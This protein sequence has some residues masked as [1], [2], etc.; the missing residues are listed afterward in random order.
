MRRS[1]RPVGELIGKAAAEKVVLCQG[2][3]SVLKNRSLRAFA[4][5]FQQLHE[6]GG[7]FPSNAKKVGCGIEIKRRARPAWTS[8]GQLRCGSHKGNPLAVGRMPEFL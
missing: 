7:L 4:Y 5:A 8:C 6:R 3:K 2:L 1:K